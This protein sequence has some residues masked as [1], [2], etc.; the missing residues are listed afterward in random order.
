MSELERSLKIYS[1][2]N[3][4]RRS[5]VTKSDFF[6]DRIIIKTFEDKIIF[7][8]PGIDYQGST[9]KMFCKNGRYITTIRGEF[10]YGVFDF[11]EDESTEDM[12]VVY[13]TKNNNEQG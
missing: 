6:K 3:M 9:S 10:P 12:I 8:K 5:I 2:D 1:G 11:D 7:K 13:L 4:N